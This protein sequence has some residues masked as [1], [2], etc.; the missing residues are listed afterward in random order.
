MAKKTPTIEKATSE[1]MN[2]QMKALQENAFQ[3]TADV[4]LASKK[5]HDT[6][7]DIAIIINSK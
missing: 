6:Q 1:E 5:Q 3:K 7:S 4:A 2:R